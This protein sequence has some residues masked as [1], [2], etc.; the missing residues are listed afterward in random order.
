MDEAQRAGLASP[1]VAEL[2]AAVA[3][4]KRQTAAVVPGPPR[5]LIPALLTSAWVAAHELLPKRLR[6]Y[7][8]LSQEAASLIE[9]EA[10]GLIDLISQL[11]EELESGAGS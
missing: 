5:N 6:G 4:M 3:R 2:Q 1:A 11:M 10:Q 7:G 9:H 8:T